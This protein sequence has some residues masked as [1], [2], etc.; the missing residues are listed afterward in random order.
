[1]PRSPYST[2]FTAVYQDIFSKGS[3]GD[4]GL[5]I[6]SPKTEKSPIEL[7]AISNML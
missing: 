4:T 3:A 2:V 1:M 6:P 5:G 7:L